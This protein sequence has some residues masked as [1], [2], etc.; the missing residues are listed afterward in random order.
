MS[1]DPKEMI[2]LVEQLPDNERNLIY[3]MIRRVY[4]AWDPDFT[5]VTPAERESMKEAEEDLKNGNFV[6]HEEILKMLDE[7]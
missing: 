1:Y 4:L 7:E 5:K 3:E 6:T 2:E